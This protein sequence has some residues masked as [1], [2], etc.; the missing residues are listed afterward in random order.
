MRRKI[1]NAAEIVLLFLRILMSL[2]KP[3]TL[4]AIGVLGRCI[5]L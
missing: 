1:V 3:D 4:F 5:P 2:K